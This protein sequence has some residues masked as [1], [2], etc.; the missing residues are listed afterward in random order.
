MKKIFFNAEVVTMV[1]DKDIHQAVL[2]EDDKIVA[3]GSNDEVLA[4]KDDATVVVD[5]EG[6]TIM[7]GF[8]DPHGHFSFQSILAECLY[9]APSPLGRVNSIED[10]KAEIAKAL[11]NHE[12]KD[13]FFI[14]YGYDN[15]ELAEG[16]HPIRDDLDEITTETPMVVIHASL[17]VGTFNTK[18]LE[19]LG[20]SETEPDMEGGHWG[21][22]PDSDV[23]NGYAE[24]L[25]IQSKMLNILSP[26]PETIPT[27]L[28][29][30]QELYAGAG[31]TTVQDGFTSDNE[32]GLMQ[33][34]VENGLIDL[35]IHSYPPCHVSVRETKVHN[36][37][38]NVGDYVGN[39]G[40]LYFSGY[41][42]VLDGSPQART[43]WMTNPYEVVSETD[44]PNYVAY[45][46]YE[47]DEEVVDAI[48]VAIDRN[49]PVL[50]HCNGDAAGDQFLRSFKKAKELSD[51]KNYDK[52]AVM[53]HAQTA[54]KDQ[55][56]IMAE[57]NIVPAMFPI[58][59]F[60]WG[61]T[62]IKN[63]G[64][65]RADKISNQAYAYEKGI[66]P[67]SHE[68]SPVLPPNPIFSAWAAQYRTTRT[69]EILGRGVNR[70]DALRTITYN[71]A[72][73]YHEEGVKG[74]IE[75]GKMSD[76]VILDTNLLTAS[77]EDMREGRVLETIKR[78]KTIFK[79]A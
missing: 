11:E 55:I 79:R 64:R 62:H 14:T 32:H 34:G 1:N 54:R 59:T 35:D 37:A 71:A 26:K 22:Y 70:F 40:R 60:F 23:I 4:M 20:I 49:A 51:N 43:A 72:H 77:K 52:R 16:R 63:F 25:A 53:I 78:G 24:E 56:D 29:A 48:K 76:L 45:P 65:E 7:P 50:V 6:K 44:D 10:M 36:G 17:H 67:T 18:A 73:Q 5:V 30:G 31:F 47:N 74:T 57:E 33:F 69:G 13:E 68:D 58:H 9:I 61:D 28:K 15:E 3:V 2:I 27:L 19:V 39:S 12:N 38:M 66:L 21:R 46:F 75:P 42:L 8:I 41:K